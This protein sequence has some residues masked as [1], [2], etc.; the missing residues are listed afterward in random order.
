MKAEESGRRRGIAQEALCM[1]MSHAAST[2]STD[3]FVAKIGFAN[4]ASLALFRKLKFAEVSRCDVF[5]EIT[6]EL[7][8][9]T[10]AEGL[11]SLL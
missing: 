11:V 7:E 10:M 4:E 3:R 1:L 9:R 6:L 2:L 8:V 5:K